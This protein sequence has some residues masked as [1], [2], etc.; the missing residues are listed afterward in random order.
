[1]LIKIMCDL[2]FKKS[3]YFSLRSKFFFV[4]NH[5][6][7]FFFFMFYYRSK[8]INFEYK[9]IFYNI[10]N[11]LFYYKVSEKSLVIKFILFLNKVLLWL[12]HMQLFV[13][14]IF[15][16]HGINIRLVRRRL[17]KKL[18]LRVGFGHGYYLPRIK[19]L[20]L[21]IYRKRYFMCA[22]YDKRVYAFFTYHLRFLRKF[23]RYKL[24]GIKFK[25]DK[26]KIRVGKKK[27]F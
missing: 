23:F 1:M 17:L 27:T 5:L 25:R 20:Y 18:Y 4:L 6:Y 9:S 16:S 2:S 10:K 11:N 3:Y 15:K 12:F 19:S 24:I 7:F 21:R 14:R 26:F 13:W 22:A 8:K